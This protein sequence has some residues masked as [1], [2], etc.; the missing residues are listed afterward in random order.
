MKVWY[1]RRARKRSFDIG[2]EVLAEQ[3]LVALMWFKRN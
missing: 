1:D 3:D 2:D